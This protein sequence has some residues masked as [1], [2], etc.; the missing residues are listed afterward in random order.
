MAKKVKL[1]LVRSLAGA[2]QRQKDTIASLGFKR[3]RRIVE[4]ELTPPIAGMIKK[5]EHLIKVHEES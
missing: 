5:V 4:K 1:E 3:R 2:K